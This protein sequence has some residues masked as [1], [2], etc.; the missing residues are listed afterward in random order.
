M[1]IVSILIGNSDDKLSQ[2]EWSIFVRDCDNAITRW[3]KEVHFS[4]GSSITSKFQNFCWV[5]ELKENMDKFLKDE[6]LNLKILH[7]QSSI[8]VVTGEVELL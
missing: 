1:K 4:G 2:M 6:L 8:A 3:S 5:V 7:H